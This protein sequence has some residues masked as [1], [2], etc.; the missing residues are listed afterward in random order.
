M[1]F[2]TV[3]CVIALVAS[4][5]G[6]DEKVEPD[7]GSD[8]AVDVSSD[9]DAADSACA[10]SDK[11][12]LC[13]EDEAALG[14]DPENED[15][16]GDGYWDGWE[17]AAGTDPNDPE[18]HPDYELPPGDGYALRVTS[19]SE[20]SALEDLVGDRLDQA[21]P[22]LLFVDG[23]SDGASDEPVY[24]QGGLGEEVSLGNDDTPNTRDDV[25][26]MTRYS[27]DQ[28]SGDYIIDLEGSV[29]SRELISTADIVR[30]NLSGFSDATKGLSLRVDDVEVTG[31]FNDTLE[32]FEDVKLIGQVS[33]EG[34][35]EL[36]EATQEILPI[37]KEQALNI[38]DPDMD[39]VIPVELGLDGR[40][41]VIEGFID[42]SDDVQAPP[43][44]PGECCPADL[45]VGDPIYGHLSWEDQGIQADE[46]DAYTLVYQAL[47]VDPDVLMFA[48]V[49][50]ELA[51]GDLIYT[52]AEGGALASDGSIS[53]RRVA[54]QGGEEETFE[55]IAENGPN[56]LANVDPTAI[57]T[58]EALL[59]LGANPASTTY[60]SKGYASG[61]ERLAFIPVEDMHYGY[62][63][64]RLTASFDDPRAGD[65][66]VL[67]A[68]WATGGF[69]NHG[70][71]SNVQ[72][73]SPLMLA[74]PG[75]RSHSDGEDAGST[76]A[77]LRDGRS[78]L[79]V[80]DAVRAV[81]IAP[82]VAAALGVAPTTGVGPDGRLRD[83]VLLS[84]QDGR[85][86]DEVFTADALTKIQNGEP[87]AKHAVIIINDGL[88]STEIL[89]QALEDGTSEAFDINNYRDLME[90]G[91]T[92]R[93]G[94]ITNFPSNTYP[95]HNVIGSGAWSGH[96]GILDNYFWERGV[97]GEERP[98]QDVYRTERLLG[99]AHANLPVETLH[100]AV[101]RTFGTESEPAMTASI[102]DPSSRGAPLATLERRF[103]DGFS[104]PEAQDT[105]TIGGTD[106]TL[107]SV[108]IDD[109]AGV[110]DNASAQTFADFY[111]DES[112]PL[113]A[114]TIVNFGSTDTAG[115]TFGPHGDQER[116]VVISRVNQRLEV[117]FATLQE[118]GI[119]DDTLVVLTSDH[120]MELQD[121]AR[122]GSLVDE[123]SAQTTPVRF[124]K[125]GK[126][127]YFK[128]LAVEV[129]DNQL[130]AG[131]N[132]SVSV[133]VTDSDTRWGPTKLPVEGVTISV[134]EGGTASQVA[135]A[136]NGRATLDIDVDAGATDVLLEFTHDEWTVERV[137]LA[138]E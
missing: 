29:V 28:T 125:V 131:S 30:L 116:D 54:G 65:V 82:T 96:H 122:M 107:P 63:F 121:E 79:M 1:R 78:T 33:D 89:Y 22:V 52:V 91:I 87:V 136:E 67:P 24:L 71:L 70:H 127:L 97:A 9:A 80:D 114:Y 21:P 123:I 134:V 128:T 72:S 64:E 119:L 86:L 25:F 31:T 53:F 133:K 35:D 41:A 104:L 13:D 58:Y 26:A 48:T 15:T 39:G 5:C 14:T 46:E 8:V 103:P 11:D 60:D 124:R 132:S 59:Q 17:H 6:P 93:Y 23:L 36:L 113:P 98:I 99:S 4:A 112:Q 111:L 84:W 137:R 40:R 38:L 108:D 73:R 61:D 75:I 95:S 138:A 7:A 34:L 92:Y 27:I 62:A 100:E 105:L 20:P 57:G 77:T 44:E 10:D 18:D 83:D 16:D 109:Y 135:T 68:S 106:Y 74:G 55:L 88:T 66:M 43:R 76:V 32:R 47:Q 94:S 129:T 117:L 49:R 126:F 110:L 50:R 19:F 102:N 12:G 90:R 120:G 115:H 51:S 69:G 56:P 101:A 85:V 118:A 81:D 2:W 3:V 130:A 45:A 42:P 37:S